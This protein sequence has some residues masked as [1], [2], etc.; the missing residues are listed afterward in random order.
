MDHSGRA[1][2]CAVGQTLDHAPGRRRATRTRRRPQSFHNWHNPTGHRH[3]RRA[4]YPA[5][6]PAPRP[7]TPPLDTIVTIS[8]GRLRGST[9][10]GVRSFKAI[11]YAAAPVGP[12]R[13]APP[14]QPE[15]WDGERDAT[16][17]GPT[18]TKPGYTP[19][20]DG[21]LPDIE[22]AGDDKLTCNVWTPEDAD[23]LPVMV[24]IHGGAFVNGSGAVAVYDGG[25]FARDGVVLVTINYRLGVDGFLFLDDGVA[26]LGLLDQ[27]A[28]LEWVRD[29]IAAF[30]GDPG[31]VTVFGESAGAMSVGT[32]LSM[33][34]ASGL[35]HRAIL[36]SGGAHHVLGPQTATRVGHALAERLGVAAD[37]EAIAEVPL[38]AL[39][40]AQRALGLEVTDPATRGQ[41][42][43]AGVNQMAFEP[44]VDGDIVP[45]PPIQAIADGG[46]DIPVMVGSNSDE[47]AFFMIPTRLHGMIDEAT[48]GMAISAYGLPEDTAARYRERH[49]GAGP[50]KVLEAILTDWFFRIPALRIAEIQAATATPAHVYEFAWD[51]PSF[52]GELGACHAL[53]I[54][55]VFDRLDREENAPMAGD[56]PPQALADRMHAAWVAFATSGDPGWPAYDLDARTTMRFDTG[57]EVVT[58]PDAGTRTLWNGIR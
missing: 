54:G 34:R 50:G 41:W 57:D 12:L 52:D 9:A 49:P 55:F 7:R 29:E 23:T 58:D 45:R 46:L 30:G 31:N 21:L 26:N 33:P 8:H 40:A 25:A 47:F 32:L 35:F 15:P 5:A 19:P 11:P 24:W 51:S 1:V 18:A 3:A 44:V 10:H 38:D 17:F 13:F 56:S 39:L 16:A 20:F 4:D 48:L 43:E 27:V 14:Q 53:E 28:A 6:A 42:A 22:I 36:Q 2:A 37:R